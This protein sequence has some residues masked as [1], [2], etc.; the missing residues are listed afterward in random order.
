MPL[1]L[2]LPVVL[3]SIQ[4]KMGYADY[5]LFIVVKVE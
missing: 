4:L 5:L 2:R 1:R 3:I